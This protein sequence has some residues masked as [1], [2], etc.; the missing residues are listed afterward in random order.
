M[1]RTIAAAAAVFAIAAFALHNSPIS[2]RFEEPLLL[3]LMGTLF[4]VVG[5]M[6]SAAPT[7]EEDDLPV[8]Q[9]QSA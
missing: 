2:G 1:Y 9:R 5:K 4:L 7:V 3:L 6:F 8:A